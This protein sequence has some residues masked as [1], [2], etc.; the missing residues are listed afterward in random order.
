MSRSSNSPRNLVPATSAPMSRAMTLR[1]LR[2]SGTS[3]ET[4]RW[5]RPSTIAV[6]P[7][8]GSPIRTGLFLVRRREDLDD[9]ADLGVAADDRVHL[10]LA[11]Q[12]DQVAAV[13]L[14]GLVLVLGVLVGHPLAA[15]HLLEG[16][17]D[18]LLGHAERPTSRSWALL[19]TFVRPSSRCSTETYS[20]FIRSASACAA[21]RTRLRSGPSVG[22]A[23]A[24][25]RQGVQA[26]LGRLEE[27]RRVDPELAQ[28][29]PD[30]RLLGVE[31]G[32]QQVH[33][34][35]PLMAPLLGELLGLLHR[36]LTLPEVS[37]VAIL[38]ADKEG[39]L[40]SAGSLI[41]PSAAAPATSTAGR[42]Y[43]PTA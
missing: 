8:P 10:A 27:L 29:R 30:D 38:D 35:Q 33:R 42:F 19:L 5:A 7:T 41:R 4:I 28:E 18:V 40:R 9:P 39:F 13:L 36:L 17:E 15:P 34:L 25:L 11:G 37:L 1:F 14:Q 21:S 23:A 20:S 2:L 32:R 22:L 3:P 43:T 31:Q 12:L 26:L 6:L 24:D 16:L